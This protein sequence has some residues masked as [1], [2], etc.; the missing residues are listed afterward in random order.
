VSNDGID[1]DVTIY[2]PT[3]SEDLEEN[4]VVVDFKTHNQKSNPNSSKRAARKKESAYIK[5]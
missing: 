4:Q 2:G 3:A 5:H 1:S